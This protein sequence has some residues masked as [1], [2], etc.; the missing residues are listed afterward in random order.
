[1]SGERKAAKH[2]VELLPLA[3]RAPVGSRGGLLRC[4]DQL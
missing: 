1:M 2:H 4:P 3:L